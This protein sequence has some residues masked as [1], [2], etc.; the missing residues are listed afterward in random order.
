MDVSKDRCLPLV[1]S[2]LTLLCSHAVAAL[3]QAVLR[4]LPYSLC[5]TL[6][7]LGLLRL[8]QAY[9]AGTRSTLSTPAVSAAEGYRER[10][11]AHK[12]R[13]QAKTWC[14]MLCSACEQGADDSGMLHAAFDSVYL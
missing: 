2:L 10:W 7:M 3:H 5:D 14:S 1:A 6:H 13:A 12:P 9:S 8:T 4:C 11:V